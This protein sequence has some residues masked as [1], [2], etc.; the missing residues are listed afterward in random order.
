MP[1]IN[2]TWYN[3][4]VNDDGSGLTGSIWDKEDV[5]QLIIATD[6]AIAGVEPGWVD[7]TLTLYAG[8]GGTISSPGA[9]GRYRLEQ[10]GARTLSLMYSIEA[11]TIAG[12]VSSVG[13]NLP[14]VPVS[15]AGIY[16]NPCCLFVSGAYEGG[17]LTV[18]SG[19]SSTTIVRSAGALF[20]QAS[21]F[22]AR[23]QIIYPI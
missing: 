2:R 23:G 18:P 14:L 6:A 19:A 10:Y 9:Y 16:A 13:F 5:N 17:W 11:A 7:Y 20:P 4:L 22:Y 21:G 3:T 12:T 15:W 8:G 1:P